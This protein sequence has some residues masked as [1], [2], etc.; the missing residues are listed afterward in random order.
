[1]NITNQFQEINLFLAENGFVAILKKLAV[2]L[3]SVIKGNGVTG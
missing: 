3:I 1:M 2:P